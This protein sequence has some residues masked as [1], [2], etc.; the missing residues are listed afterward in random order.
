VQRFVTKGNI[1][2]LSAEVSKRQAPEQRRRTKRSG[3]RSLIH[4]QS[5]CRFEKPFIAVVW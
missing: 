3:R 4:L 5:D 2:D 1:I